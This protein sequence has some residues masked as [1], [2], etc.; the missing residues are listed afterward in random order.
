MDKLTRPN[1]ATLSTDLRQAAEDARQYV[2]DS[3]PA[4]TKRAYATD[5]ATFSEWCR[6]HKLA[7]LPA[8]PKTVALFAA[9][10][11]K[12]VRPAT[13]RRAL[14]AIGKVHRVSGHPSPCALEPV[15]STIKGIERTH[16]AA[17]RGKAPANLAAVETMLTAFPPTTLDG[18]RNRAML[19]VGFAGAF[20]R[21]E[22]VALVV[23]DLAWSDDGV[24]VT[25]RQSKTDQR[26]QGMTKA[27]PFVSG[28]SARRRPSR[29]GWWRAVSR[30][31]RCSGR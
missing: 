2:R 1:E 30:T 26:G 28:A 18:I 10:R 7:N 11:A 3:V 13:I 16:G 14:A 5:W 23:S 20:R 9:D 4:S 15:P 17:V 29:R 12:A 8:D 21:A 24:V 22:L 27:I 6:Q 19:L 31:G 25:V